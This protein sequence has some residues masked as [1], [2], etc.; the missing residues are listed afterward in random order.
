M[1]CPRA[2][3]FDLDDTLAESFHAPAPETLE[4]LKKLLGHIP[5]AIMTGAGFP[6][7]QEQFL[8]AIENAAG[9]E[10]FYL[11]PT[12]TS[13][14]YVYREGSWQQ[15]Y[16][17]K[18]THEERTRIKQIIEKVVAGS[19]ILSAVRGFGERMIDH[20]AQVAFTLVGVDAPKDVK[21]TWDIDG[22][23][24]QFLKSELQR[25]TSE[26]EVLLGGRTTVDI[27]KKG[28]NK[29]HGVTWLSKELGIPP[30]EML[31]VGDAFFEGGND[32]VVIPTGIQ[33]RSVSGPA[34]TPQVINE[35]LAACKA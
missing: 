9:I 35:L 5:I 15:L 18:L 3:L 11:F 27:T 19:E 12:S 4:G 20:E 30:Q 13:E 26:F 2:V 14:C 33:T 32:A 1:Q 22:S 34:E 16:S 23:K 21:D 10:R 17:I 31:Y 25:A 6:R 8:S 28:V 7:M 29:F 24:R